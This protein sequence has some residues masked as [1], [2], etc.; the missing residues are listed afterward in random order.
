MTKGKSC[1]QCAHAALGAYKAAVR[2]SASQRTAL[3]A[4]EVT[5]QTKIVL[6]AGS[7]AELRDLAAR[8]RSAGLVAV[9]VHDA[10]HTQV[11]AGSATVLAVGPDAEVAVN[12]VTGHLKLL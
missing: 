7:E 3:A 8:A 12:A 9:I 11:A 1:A 6:R 4:W 10:G 2:G 5:G